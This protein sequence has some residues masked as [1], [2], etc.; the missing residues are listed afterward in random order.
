M[1]AV[2]PKKTL[3]AEER[4]VSEEQ[5]GGLRDGEEPGRRGGGGDQRMAL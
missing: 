1:A 4:L 3:G 2:N 5:V